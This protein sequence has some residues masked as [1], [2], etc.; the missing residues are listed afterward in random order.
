MDSLLYVGTTVKYTD[1]TLLCAQENQLNS[2]NATAP[3]PY[4]ES[5]EE[6]LAAEAATAATRYQPLP[7]QQYQPVE[8]L[9][10]V[11]CCLYCSFC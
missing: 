10:P 8:Q 4:L 9:A 11:S 3:L 2:L 1:D 6:Y 5:V 7:A